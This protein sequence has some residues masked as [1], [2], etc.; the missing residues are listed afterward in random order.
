M[1]LRSNPK[2][3]F[4]EL[5]S[6]ASSVDDL[7]RYSQRELRANPCWESF[8]VGPELGG[9]PK[10]CHVCQWEFATNKAH[11]LRECIEPYRKD[12]WNTAPDGLVACQICVLA[13]PQVLCLSAIALPASYGSTEQVDLYALARWQRCDDL[14]A[15]SLADD[16]DLCARTGALGRVQSGGTGGTVNH[17]DVCVRGDGGAM[18]MY[19]Y[20]TQGIGLGG[21]CGGVA[22]V[23]C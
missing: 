12:D 17:C 1:P 23:V 14:L 3:S 10:F 8:D 6:S 5:V 18:K 2:S 19:Y 7:P 22:L 13:D 15:A 4:T 16:I 11:G 9:G 20:G 21:V